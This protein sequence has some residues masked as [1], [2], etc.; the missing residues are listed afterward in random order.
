MLVLTL[1]QLYMSGGMAFWQSGA[2]SVAYRQ[3]L[4]AFKSWPSHS[5]AH[6]VRQL[7]S[8]SSRATENKCSS[9]GHCLKYTYPPTHDRWVQHDIQDAEQIDIKACNLVYQ[10]K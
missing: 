9:R 4:I 6:H 10:D 2:G 3:Y 7:K 8:A 5:W 1:L